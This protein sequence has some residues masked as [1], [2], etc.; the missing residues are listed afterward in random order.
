[1]LVILITDLG[2]GEAGDTKTTPGVVFR[3]QLLATSDAK[4]SS[5]QYPIKT[6]PGRCRISKFIN[7]HR[8]YIQNL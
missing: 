5:F 6:T 7:I 8:T 1:M 2:G 3:K 4:T